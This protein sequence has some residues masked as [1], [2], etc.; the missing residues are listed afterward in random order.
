MNKAQPKTEAPAATQTPTT[1]AAAPQ[2]PAATGKAKN[3][4]EMSMEEKEAYLDS[5]G[6]SI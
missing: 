5:Q 1:Q 2:V 3:Y 4:A 6:G